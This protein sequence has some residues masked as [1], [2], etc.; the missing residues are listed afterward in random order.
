MDKT[1]YVEPSI[2]GDFRCFFSAANSYGTVGVR[3]GKPFYEPTKGELEI[4]EIK[5]SDKVLV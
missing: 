1:L 3:N 4:R 5:Y 2:K